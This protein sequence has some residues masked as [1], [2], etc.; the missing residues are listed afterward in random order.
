MPVSSEFVTLCQTQIRLLTQALEASISVV[1]LTED[2]VGGTQ[3]RLVAIAAYPETLVEYEKQANALLLPATLTNQEPIL[4][5]FI[6]RSTGYSLQSTTSDRFIEALQ[7]STSGNSTSSEANELEDV[8]PE[9]A[10]LVDQR[11]IVIPLIYEE[12][13]F[14]FLVTRRDHRG[15][16]GWEQS[17][18]EEIAKTLAI[19]CV[20]DQR[21]HWSQREREHERLMQLQQH[22][23]FDNLLHQFRNSLTALHTFGKLVLKRLLPGDRSYDLATSIT[24]ETERLRELAQQMEIALNAGSIQPPRSLPSTSKTFP[25]NPEKL[26]AATPDP[27]PVE[28]PPVPMLTTAGLLPGASLPLERCLIETILEPLLTS[29]KEIAQE[30]GLTLHPHFSEELPPIWANAQALRE[31]FTNLIENAIKYTP[32]GGHIWVLAETPDESAFLKVSISDTGL[33]IPSEDLPHLFERHYRGAKAQGDIPGSGLGLAIAQ[34][35]IEQ[36][37]GKI[38]VF[39]PA[40]PHKLNSPGNISR[41]TS[42]GSTFL[43]YLPLAVGEIL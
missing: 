17:Q 25:A 5:Q 40:L 28:T 32:V 43:V 34:S 18:V 11:Q 35:L 38:Q 27:Q 23:L 36:M 22:D 37:H 29:A 16:E 39:S 20:L 4:N 21:Y 41:S 10:G 13:V 15:W 26:G 6:D 24:R 14:G 19:A 3:S 9:A 8:L 31:V 33:G 42:G 7:Y 2:L 1:Y 12:V 30:K